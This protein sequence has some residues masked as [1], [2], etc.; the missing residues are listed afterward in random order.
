MKAEERIIFAAGTQSLKELKYYLATFQGEIGAVR[1]GREL[2]GSDRWD[3][4][5]VKYILNETP[6]E[7][8]W[9]LKYDD[10]PTT[11]VGAAKQAEKYGRERIFGFTV[12]YSSGKEVMKKAVEAVEEKFGKGLTTPVI[13]AVD[14]LK[15]LDEIE[16]R[17]ALGLLYTSEGMILSLAKM[18]EETGA[19]AIICSPQETSDVL[20][21][22]P[23]F[24]VINYGVKFAS[25]GT[26]KLVT[27]PGQAIANGASYIIMGSDLRQGDPLANVRRAVEEIWWTL[28]SSAT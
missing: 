24:V 5:V 23:N 19:R 18:A 7:I 15:S 26:Q 27:T 17:E 21:V 4:P 8:M 12:H 3:D 25:L 10:I 14:L 22:N 20:E 9:D 1:L 6:H 28:T 13:I 11:V 2:L 16:L